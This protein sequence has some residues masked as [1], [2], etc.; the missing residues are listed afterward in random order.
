LWF[1]LSKL[2]DHLLCPLYRRFYLLPEDSAGIFSG[3]RLEFFDGNFGHEMD[4]PYFPPH[5]NHWLSVDSSPLSEE[6]DARFLCAN[7]PAGSLAMEGREE[8]P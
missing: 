8:H 5:K 7:V 3:Q 2:A 4:S 1:R 6:M